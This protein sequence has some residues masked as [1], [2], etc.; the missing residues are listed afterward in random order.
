LVILIINAAFHAHLLLQAS[1]I[2]RIATP[3]HHPY[4]LTYPVRS[5]QKIALPEDDPLRRIKEF[6]HQP[7]EIIIDAR[8]YNQEH[9]SKRDRPSLTE[10]IRSEIDAC[11][12]AVA[13][14]YEEQSRRR[15]RHV[16]AP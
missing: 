2:I 5:K 15:S 13:K 9:P 16:L 14:V 3:P 6:V 1:P 10:G 7:Q 4:P 12:T 11:L 8:K